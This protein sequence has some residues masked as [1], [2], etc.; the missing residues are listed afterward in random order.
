MIAVEE[1]TEEIINE[2]PTYNH[3]YIC[4]E[5]IIQILALQKFRPLPELTLNIG[6]GIT[7][8]ISVYP[9]ELAPQPNFFSDIIRYDKMPHL[10]IEVVSPSQNIQD[11]LEKAQMLIEAGAKTVWTVEPFSH[12]IWVTNEEGTKLFHNTT[13]ESEGITVDFQKIFGSDISLSA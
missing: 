4:L 11:L 9:I 13:I 7:P 12:S 6:K 3:S 10:A 1:T 5:I 2:M 8:D